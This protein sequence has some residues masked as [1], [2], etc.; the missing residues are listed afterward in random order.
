MRFEILEREERQYIAMKM[1]NKKIIWL[2]GMM[3][4]LLAF[5]GIK[6]SARALGGGLLISGNPFSPVTYTYEGDEGVVVKNKEFVVSA[7]AGA[8]Y[9]IEITFSTMIKQRRTKP[10][11]T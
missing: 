4:F 2:A 7:R 11:L 6:I 1:G 9:E 5:T 8:N 10:C 3:A